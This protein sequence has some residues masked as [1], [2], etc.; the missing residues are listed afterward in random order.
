MVPPWSNLPIEACFF[1]IAVGW[2][3]MFV[4]EATKIKVRSGRSWREILFGARVGQPVLV[5]D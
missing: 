5:T 2:S 1:W 3:A 4:H